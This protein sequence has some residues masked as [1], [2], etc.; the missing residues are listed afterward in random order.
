MGH[1]QSTFQSE[2][3]ILIRRYLTGS[4]KKVIIITD[5]SSEMDLIYY[6]GYSHKIFNTKY[7]VVSIIRNFYFA[8]KLY[9]DL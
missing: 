2:K 9:L 5:R 4:K 1:K 6:D 7:S 3:H 8:A